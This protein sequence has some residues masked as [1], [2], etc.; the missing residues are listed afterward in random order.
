MQSS[1]MRQIA[2]GVY[3]IV[4]DATFKKSSLRSSSQSKS[5]SLGGDLAEFIKLAPLDQNAFDIFSGSWSTSFEGVNTLGNFPGT[6]DDRIFWLLDNVNLENKNVLELGPLEAAHTY[7]LEK[8]GANVTAVEANK[9]AFL[10][11][12]IVKN[13]FG[14]NAKFLLGDFEKIDFENNHFDLVLASGVLYHMTDPVGFLKNLSNSTERIFF[15]THYFD[16]DLDKWNPGLRGRLDEGKWDYKNPDIVDFEGESVR[17][18]RQYYGEALGWSGFCGGTDVYSKW[19]FKDDLISLLR[20]L[21]FKNLKISFD[22]V[23]HQNGPS[24]CVLAEK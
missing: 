2:F 5:P 15:W 7:M 8:A 16:P 4:R 9:G 24:F 20:K 23:A 17:L 11:S 12:L 1:G 3:A 6:K 14:L 22:H 13:Y 21:G 18:V 10:R 19:I